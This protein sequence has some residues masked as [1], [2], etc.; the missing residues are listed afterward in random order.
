MA[1]RFMSTHPSLGHPQSPALC[2]WRHSY[3]AS[4]EPARTL[5]P[6]LPQHGGSHEQ[7]EMRASHDLRADLRLLA[8][9]EMYGGEQLFGSDDLVVAG[10]EQ[11]HRA[12]HH[13]EIDRASERCET[14]GCKLI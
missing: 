2:R 12:S 3:S 8:A 4:R 9:D 10:R 6:I 7:P 11:E 14:A 13:R 5:R 1:G